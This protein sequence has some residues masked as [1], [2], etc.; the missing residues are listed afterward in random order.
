MSAID[1]GTRVSGR[2]AGPQGEAAYGSGDGSGWVLF[3]AIIMGIVGV[4][5]A[6]YGIAAIGSSS[7]F[8]ED[9]R[10][11]FEGLHTWGWIALIVGI[12]QLFACAS[13]IR[14]GQFGRWF[15]I[16]AAGVNSITALLSMPAY[17]FWSLAIFAVDL[18]IIYGLA[19]YGRRR[20]A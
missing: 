9:Q 2:I 18:M 15:G 14:G 8:V 10:Y 16:G 6:I 4:L 5:N 1:P 19:A 7:F 13:V 11:I 20:P 3:A 12:V 17:P